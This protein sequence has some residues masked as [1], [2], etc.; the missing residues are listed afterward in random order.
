MS[1]SVTLQAAG[2]NYSP[3][4]LSLPPGSMVQADD[5][6]IKRDNV[7]ESRRGYREYAVNLGLSTDLPKQLMEYKNRILVHYSNK[8][9]FDTG[10]TDS[11]GKA[12]FEN[13]TGNYLEPATGTK[14]KW[15]EAVN[16]NLYFTS[17]TG[18]QKISASSNTQF[19]DGTVQIGPAGAVKALDMTATLKIVQGQISGFLPPDTA[20][21]YRHLW[22]YKDN[23]KNLVLG[24]P[25]ERVE[26]Y[27][28]LSDIISL[29]LN[30]LTLILDTL[31]QGTSLITDGNYS[32]SYY[33][34]INPDISAL[35]N[36]VLSLAQ[37]LDTDIQFVNQGG[38]SPLQIATIGV[39]NNVVTITFASGNPS[40]Y[41][42][43][44]DFIEISGINS[45]S[46]VSI[47]GVTAGNPT[48]ITTASPHGLTT[49]SKVTLSGTNTNLDGEQ[50]VTV[51]GA[52]TFTVPVNTLLSIQS[53]GIGTTTAITTT[54]GHGFQTGN[55]ISLVGTNST[56]T[57]NGSHIITVTSTNS[58]TIAVT[59]SADA[60]G[61]GATASP[62]ISSGTVTL[63]TLS[64]ANGS[65]KLTAVDATTLQFLYALPEGTTESTTNP[66]NI[67]LITP[68]APNNGTIV[69]SYSYENITTTGDDVFPVS[70][71]DTEISVPATNGQ[72]EVIE[73]TINRIAQR[74]KAE[75]NGVIPTALLNEYVVP[76][77]IT[78]A[79]NAEIKVTIPPQIALNPNYFLQIYR[80][81]NFV[82][83]DE[84]TLGGSGG[85][86]VIPNDEMRLVF[87]V[88]PTSAELAAGTVTFLDETPESLVLNNTNLYTNPQSGVGINQQND[89]PPYALDI[90]QFK[91]TLFYANTRTQQTIP[92][93]QLLGVSNIANGDT[94][95]IADQLVSITYTFVT[96]VNQVV[97]VTTT[98]AASITDGAYFIVYSSE[99]ETK[100]YF[101]Y[102]IDDSGVT[103]PTQTDGINVRI[104]I[105][106]TFTNIE[107][108]DR[109]KD[110]VNG[111]IYDFT[112]DNGGTATLS[113]TNVNEGITN[114]P[115]AGT[116]GF[117]V[118]VATAGDGE[119]AATK[120]VLRSNL[121][122]AAQAVEETARSLV[123]VI[124][125]QSNSDISAYYVSSNTSPPG[126]IVLQ[127]KT[128][129]EN[130]FYVITSSS[131]IGSSFNPD[132]SP[133]FTD[134]T[135]ISVGNPTVITVSSPHGLSNT[136]SIVVTN[137]NSTPSI[138][139]LHKVTVLSPTTFSIPVIVTVAG[140]RGS[141]STIEDTTVS[142]NDVNV[143]RLYYS[144]LN[145]PE[146]V[147]IL[148]Y[149]DVGAG[150]KSILRIFPLRDTLF[151]FKE[152]GLYR[153]SGET[154]PFVL[155]LFDT[156][157]IL[158]AAETVSV[159]NNKIYGWTI[160]GITE[161]TETGAKEVSRPIDTEVL[162]IGSASFPNFK[163]LSWGTGYDSDNSY[164]VYTNKDQTDTVANI[165][166]RYCTLTN[167][168]T[169][170]N[171][172]QNCGLVP[173]FDDKLYMGSGT[174]STVHQERKNF[175][176]TDYADTDFTV[177]LA[178]A[179]L[180]DNG[181]VLNFTSVQDIVVGDV[182]TQEQTLSIFQFNS[183][184]SQMDLDPTIGFKNYSTLA[185]VPGD[186]LRDK[187]V[188]LAAKMDTDTGL[189]FTDYS[190]RIASHSGTITSN[191]IASQT[192]VTASDITN[193]INGRV[194]TIT[195]T[196]T[197]ASID[198]IK[199]TNQVSNTGTFGSATTFSLPVVVTTA[200]G[201]GLT[202]TT[203]NNLTNFLDIQACFNEIIARLN[204]DPGATFNDYLPTTGTT[205]F[206]AVIIAV[207]YRLNR[208][209]LNLPLQWI[210][211]DM[212]IYN[213]I[214][215]EFTYAPTTFGDPLTTK[216]IAECTIMFDNKAF[217][218]ASASFSS[219][220]VPV[221]YP[222]PIFGDGN[223]IFGHYS[224][225]GFGYGHFGG[226]SNGA[227]FRTY[228]PRNTQRCRYVNLK[229]SHSIA[230]EIWAIYGATLSGRSL[231]SIRG[232]R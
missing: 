57:I 82:A 115:S 5:I 230:R 67:D 16:K 173:K 75:L 121:V 27:N 225:P 227:P 79:A 128:L 98:A 34:P 63:P 114:A 176:R 100:Y 178:K 41:M 212:T 185:A 180:F 110:V 166:Y 157:C 113:I 28:F 146:A 206:E 106:S 229:F 68:T 49:G 17:S 84:Q 155:D 223:G 198:P 215:C 164:I 6:I 139:G 90:N 179:S 220:L 51:T 70:L 93:F 30:K 125:K 218:T 152:D 207:D 105:L 172:I 124:N 219:D 53:V 144:K 38:A 95:T 111:L 77:N 135:N 36:T 160:K 48:T 64:F 161:V 72:E 199:G 171:R 87:E 116:S 1:S 133:D 61:S 167:T 40:L 137:S 108:A 150:D 50:V 142:T 71:T 80:T 66:A 232:Y 187:I 118:S 32:D 177:T 26:L 44:G 130:P 211:G 169:N 86:P 216:Q 141:W 126:Q 205:L 190:A 210:V 10:K 56:P 91:N 33:S 189:S 96:G 89:P 122:S 94:L 83:S 12:I 191:S 43:I 78:T 7:V 208:I 154:A 175:D 224:K 74:L 29:D 99:N 222:V 196:Q 203:A 52:S 81:A 201:T 35:K 194:V 174:A 182:I 165:A 158:T 20:V 127:N 202:F 47:S 231:E 25:S 162:K 147:P 69:N 184:L 156:S 24:D 88:F 22:G 136:D 186:S 209:T 148:N 14:I 37:Q 140:T 181:T 192:L 170:F 97:D 132:S 18:V 183:L 188:A 85:I 168:W 102:E 65:W 15:I 13:F 221:F 159:S 163:T 228:V 2:L 45:T 39:I 204:N 195:G 153:V 3:N 112:S 138:D 54:T 119:D 103:G 109:T 73:N 9:A 23:N 151:V 104:P 213:A 214:N 101:Y 145:Q 143:N 134:I 129:N 131:G 197:P 123:R 193:L 217:S 76:Y 21:A 46:T 19:N 60:T 31:N 120:H 4:L 62:V 107:V 92:S 149:F 117:S 226:N 59:T 11:A 200:G 42:S 58:F 8:I 55:T